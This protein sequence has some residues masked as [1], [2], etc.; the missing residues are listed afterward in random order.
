MKNVKLIE[1][2]IINSVFNEK[3]I[4]INA[5]FDHTF[6]GYHPYDKEELP[7]YTKMV[8]DKMIDFFKQHMG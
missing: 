8:A 4:V 7:Q 3:K 6:S 5:L 1:K 2:I